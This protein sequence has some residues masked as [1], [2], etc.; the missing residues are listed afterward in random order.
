MTR[1]RLWVVVM[2]AALALAGA[3]ALAQTPPAKRPAPTGQRRPTPPRAVVRTAPVTRPVVTPRPVTVRV[4]SYQPHRPPWIIQHLGV[5]LGVGIPVLVFGLSI[6]GALVRKARTVP[7]LHRARARF[8]EFRQTLQR[9]SRLARDAMD[10]RQQRALFNFSAQEYATA[11]SDLVSICTRHRETLEKVENEARQ[12][13]RSLDALEATQGEREADAIA[14]EAERESS[15]LEAYGERLT[16]I[17]RERL[18]ALTALQTAQAAAGQ[19]PTAGR[20]PQMTISTLAAMADSRVHCRT[21]GG[22]L[23]PASGTVAC[24]YCGSPIVPL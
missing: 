20:T 23:D 21:C 2:V 11:A 8:A 14:D 17:L 18:D 15:Q 1:R 12:L 5:I 9:E 10:A 13:S 19:A 22:P 7:K 6:V 24:A 16:G 3:T 4:P